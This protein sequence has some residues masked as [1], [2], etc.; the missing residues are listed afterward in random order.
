MKTFLTWI[1]RILTLIAI[2]FLAVRLYDQYTLLPQIE[3]NLDF[4][5]AIIA[6]LLLTVFLNFTG[7]I[8]WNLLLKIF[9]V[10]TSILACAK[11]TMIAQIGKY[12]PGNVFH[13][14]GRATIGKTYGIKNSVTVVTIMIETITVIAVSLTIFIT[15]SL[16]N[17]E[18]LLNLYQFIPVDHYLDNKVF[19]SLVI[20]AAVLLL[21]SFTVLYRGTLQ[22]IISIVT[23]P[24]SYYKYGAVIL[25]Y[26][27]SFVLIGLILFVL[28]RSL[29]PEITS[30]SL[31][32]YFWI[33][34]FAWVAGFVVPGAPGGIGIREAIFL[35]L[36]SAS[37]G[38]G[39]AITLIIGHRIIMIAG[40][41]LTLIAGKL[42]KTVKPE[43]LIEDGDV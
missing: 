35:L 8:I 28:Q 43:L 37:L 34:S 36:F 42:I 15:G 10:N 3:F 18:K 12:L 23:T 24:G 30:I 16:F 32:Q 19:I 1:G 39:N 7:G 27:F 17:P 5:I 14:V 31:F 41:F 4:L 38:E 25:L 22:K 6:G 2:G 20:L 40:D 21:I 33:F 9:S 11:I 29:F 26:V 13:Y